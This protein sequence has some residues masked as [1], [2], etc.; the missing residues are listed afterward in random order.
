LNEEEMNV[1][2]DYTEMLHDRVKDDIEE[3]RKELRYDE[4][5][6][7]IRTEKL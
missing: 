4:E 1:D 6:N 2:P 3:T 5:K 7:R